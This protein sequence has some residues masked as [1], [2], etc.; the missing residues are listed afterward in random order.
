MSDIIGPT[1]HFLVSSSLGSLG[2]QVKMADF[3]TN[4]IFLCIIFT[5]QIFGIPSWELPSSPKTKSDTSDLLDLQ[6]FQA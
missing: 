3:L 6:V 4:K 2:N 1:E 5:L